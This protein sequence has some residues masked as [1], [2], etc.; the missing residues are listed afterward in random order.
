MSR[1]ASGV[2]P[3]RPIAASRHTVVSVTRPRALPMELL[4]CALGLGL[5]ALVMCAGHVVRGG[6]YYDDWSVLALGRF[7]PPGGLLHG[8]WLDYGQRPGQVLYYAALDELL[9]SHASPRLALAA[10]TLVLEATCLYALLRRLGL[11][12]RDAFAIAALSLAFPFSDSAWLW[13]ILSLASLALAAALLGVILALR[14]LERAG[15]RALALH[16]LSLALFVGSLLS[17]EVFALAGCLAGLLYVRA[18]GFARARVRW[19]LDV[20]AIV[21]TLVLTRSVLPTDVATPS[22][23]QPLAGMVAHAGL[24]AIQGVQVAGA[25]ALPV[26]GVSPWLGAGLLAAVLAGAA[27][28]RRRLPRGDTARAELG[29]WLSLAAVGALIAS[30]AWAVYVPAPDH[31]SPTALN[32]VNRM[33]LGA[34]IGIVLLLYSCLRLLAGVLAR[35]ARR[36]ASVIAF[37]VTVVALALG[38][39]YLVRTAADARAWDAAAGDQRGVLEDLHRALPLLPP[40]AALYAFDMPRFAGPGIPVLPTTLDLTSAV[41]LSYASPQVTGIPVA[42]AAS[43]VCGPR[44]VQA[45]GVGS[46]YG[47]AYLVDVDARRAVRLL[48][49]ERCEAT[50]TAATAAPAPNPAPRTHVGGEPAKNSVESARIKIKPGATKHNPP[51]S[52]PRLPRKRHEQ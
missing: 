3:E 18:A 10:V 13:G 30:V 2:V 49:R 33:N 26:S 19:A 34:A 36:S 40:A 7:P 51:T 1:S 43:V 21:P 52:A 45:A 8:L 4:A 44:G 9:G 24:I 15:A 37:C 42:G 23:T 46:S 31:Y 14:A 50:A 22:R 27:A 41:R 5:I 47:E 35:P 48:S 20:C 16:G 29:R 25:A 12:A 32:T 6:L 38:V 28:L 11:A 39:A 17:Y